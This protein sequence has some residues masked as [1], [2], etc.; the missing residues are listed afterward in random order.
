MPAP[1]PSGSGLVQ[2]AS[3]RVGLAKQFEETSYY[4]KD[5][6][7]VTANVGWAVGAPHWDQAAKAYAGTIVK[8]SDGGQTW[9][10]QA[11]GVSQ[12]LRGVEF[13]DLDHGWAVGAKGTILHTDGRRG[14]LGPANRG[15]ERRVPRPGLCGPQPG[16]G[17]RRPPD[18]L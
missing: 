12:T 3:Y 18:P 17:D 8:T 1:E 14:A 10:P 13:V 4:F 15:H 2:S 9:T 16:L 7:M 6:D 11:A 5:V